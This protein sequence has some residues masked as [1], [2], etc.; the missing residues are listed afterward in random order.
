MQ[1]SRIPGPVGRQILP[2]HGVPFCGSE[3][4]PIVVR[5]VA[6]NHLLRAPSLVFGSIDQREVGPSPRG[7][8]RDVNVDEEAGERLPPFSVK[9]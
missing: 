5:L 7:V 6:V 8:V 4:D 3:R 2:K 1:G 9:E